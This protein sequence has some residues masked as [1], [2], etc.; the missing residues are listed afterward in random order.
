[1]DIARIVQHWPV[2]FS[3]EALGSAKRPTTGLLNKTFLLREAGVLYVL[4]SVHPAVA[5]DGS[6][7]N[8]DNVTQFLKSKG[9]QT[10]T[11]VRTNSGALW[12]EEEGA[13]WRLLVGVEGVTHE[14][15]TDPALA[16]EAGSFLGSF[17]DVLASYPHALDEGRRSFVYEGEI[18]RLDL[19]H[20]ELMHDPDPRMGEAAELLLRE[21]P[22]LLLPKDLPERIIHTDPKISNFL[23]SSDGRAVSMIDLDALQVLSP[24][25][26]LGDAIRSWCGQAEDDPNN[27]FNSGIYEALVKGYTGALKTS[28]LSEREVALIPNA[29][30]LVM[31]GLTTRF[32]NDYID[33]SYF[34]WDATRYTSRK[35][36][37][38]ARVMGQ[39]SLYKTFEKFQANI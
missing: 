1:M 36:H 23:F 19:Y 7:K 9:F 28:P 37:N 35:D 8:Y 32:L 6:F 3:A 4:Q 14:F 13:R 20:D 25:Y 11:F 2:E 22:H 15:T 5:F 16:R 27:T 33:D 18:E 29:A 38:K 34:G 39:L 10:Q 21:L 12:H 30:K 24:L 31:L 26:D 17:T